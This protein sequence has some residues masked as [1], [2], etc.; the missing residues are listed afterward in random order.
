MFLN[1]PPLSNETLR[2][3]FEKGGEGLWLALR[4]GPISKKDRDQK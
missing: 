3:I 2:D 4:Q 1:V